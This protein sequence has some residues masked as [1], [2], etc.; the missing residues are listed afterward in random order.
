MIQCSSISWVVIGITFSSCLLAI[1]PCSRRGTE[2][3]YPKV[4]HLVL[5]YAYFLPDPS[6]ANIHFFCLLERAE[7]GPSATWVE[8]HVRSPASR[9]ELASCRIIPGHHSASGRL[10]WVK[11][12][13]LT[14]TLTRI[15]SI[16]VTRGP[17]VWDNSQGTLDG[18]NLPDQTYI[19]IRAADLKMKASIRAWSFNYCQNTKAGPNIVHPRTYFKSSL[20]KPNSRSKYIT[21]WIS[22]MSEF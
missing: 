4:L 1:S 10:K 17:N 18:V 12:G 2:I 8:R 9:H 13:W 16:P 21:T 3:Y 6:C 22:F 20:Q 19:F 5:P 7:E 15:Q 14:M 11:S